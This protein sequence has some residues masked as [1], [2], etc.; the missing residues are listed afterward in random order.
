[1]DA[2]T[3]FALTDDLF[4]RALPSRLVVPLAQL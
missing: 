4:H 2:V 1:M 3:V